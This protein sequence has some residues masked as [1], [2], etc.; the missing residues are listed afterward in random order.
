MATAVRNARAVN[1]LVTASLFGC[2][3]MATASEHRSVSDCTNR[4][5]F[6][7]RSSCAELV[8]VLV[9]ADAVNKCERFAQDRS[10]SDRH[11]S[12]RQAP[13]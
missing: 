4:P 8:H 3:F 7:V 1:Q 13:L 11:S 5:L 12:C 6:A 2:L 10:R 9:P